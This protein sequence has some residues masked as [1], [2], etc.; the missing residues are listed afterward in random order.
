MKNLMPGLRK[1][2]ENVF[3]IQKELF[4]NEIQY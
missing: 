2:T 1:F 4:E 3:P